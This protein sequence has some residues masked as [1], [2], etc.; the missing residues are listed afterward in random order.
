MLI[1]GACMLVCVCIVHQCLIPLLT[2]DHLPV[3]SLNEL[4]AQATDLWVWLVPHSHTQ[5]EVG[6]NLQ[7]PD[8]DCFHHCTGKGD[9]P[10]VST[11]LRNQTWDLLAKHANYSTMKLCAF[12][13]V[14]SFWTELQDLCPRSK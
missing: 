10:S 2:W 4:R 12:V 3:P 11:Q 9:C 13:F 14:V 1:E 8:S 6:H 7:L 5:W